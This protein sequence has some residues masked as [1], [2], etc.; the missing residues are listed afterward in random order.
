M[1]T[2]TRAYLFFR[3]VEHRLQMMHQFK[4]HSI[5]ESTDEIRLLAKRVS[6][7]PLGAF[8][9]DSFIS[10]LATHLNKIRHLGESFFAGEGMPDK[11]RVSP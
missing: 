6:L 8:T 1:K 10:T 11:D 2:M 3:L 4:T 5:P 7:G 9:Y